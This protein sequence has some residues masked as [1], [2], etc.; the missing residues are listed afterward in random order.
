MS[1][2][3]STKL[4]VGQPAPTFSLPATGNRTISLEDY[5]GK[6]AVVLYFYPKDDTPGCTTEACAFRDLESTFAEAGA[7]I[8]GV[9]ADPVDSHEAFARKFSLGFPLLADL[10]VAVANAY[11]AYGTKNLYGKVSQGV[12]RHTFVIDREGI[13]R[14]IYPNVKVDQHADEV[15]AFL[16]TL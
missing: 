1:S 11:G 9:S 8:L 7:A 4:T 13:L 2:E 12:L 16:H 14:K 10:D 6:Q 15:L 3:T 5:K